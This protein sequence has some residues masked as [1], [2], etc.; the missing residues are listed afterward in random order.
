VW[1][2]YSDKNYILEILKKIF[3]SSLP[4]EI[5]MYE[6]NYD[7][8]YLD[9]LSKFEEDYSEYYPYFELK[10]PNLKVSSKF[11]DNLH[12]SL[13]DNRFQIRD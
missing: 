12:K 11:I 10:D 13:D 1:Y 8:L 4:E 2:N 5:E 7:E 3:K 9:N 6:A